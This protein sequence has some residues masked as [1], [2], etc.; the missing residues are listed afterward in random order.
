MRLARK[1]PRQLRSRCQLRPRSRARHADGRCHLACQHLATRAPLWLSQHQQLVLRDSDS[2]SEARTV[3]ACLTARSAPCQAW[4]AWQ[5]RASS[6][7]LSIPPLW[8]AQGYVQCCSAC[9]CF[10][11]HAIMWLQ[12]LA[13]KCCY[14]YSSVYKGF[15]TFRLAKLSVKRNLSIEKAV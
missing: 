9:C 3:V 12:S 15:Q 10:C 6:C 5:L 4:R 14:L 7:Q 2:G 1:F 11:Y 8:R 13:C